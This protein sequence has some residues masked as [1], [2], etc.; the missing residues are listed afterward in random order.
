MLH[1]LTRHIYVV[2]LVCDVIYCHYERRTL[3]IERKHSGRRE[4]DNEKECS[5]RGLSHFPWEVM[6]GLFMFGS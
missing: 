5:V 6:D 4:P 2:I 3:T 1:L